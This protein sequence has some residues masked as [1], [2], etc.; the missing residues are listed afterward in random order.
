MAREDA[1][2][3]VRIIK[4]RKCHEQDVIYSRPRTQASNDGKG[5]PP[6]EEGEEV[7]EGKEPCMVVKI[8]KKHHLMKR[9]HTFRDFLNSKSKAT[10]SLLLQLA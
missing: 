2:K 9:K 8:L 6:L 1:E 7:D 3:K 4:S 10:E 5:L